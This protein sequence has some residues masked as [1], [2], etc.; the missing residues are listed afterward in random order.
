MRAGVRL[1]AGGR[2]P[3]EDGSQRRL[4]DRAGPGPVTVSSMVPGCRPCRPPEPG[5]PE[6]GDQG[7]VGERLDVLDQ[8]R[9]APDAAC[10]G[11][12]RAPAKAGTAPCRPLRALTTAD[13][14]PE[15]K[16]SAASDHLDRRR[17]ER[18]A[19]ALGDGGV[20]GREQVARA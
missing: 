15:M 14:W 2:G 18:T 20:H 7:D 11:W 5:R 17:V 1:G 9:P 16:V 13:S 8:R 4:D 3:P 12:S 6:A 19:A 10:R